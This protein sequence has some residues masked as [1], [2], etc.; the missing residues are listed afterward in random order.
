MRVC[1][2]VRACECGRVCVCVCVNLGMV[3]WS[4]GEWSVLGGS[5]LQNRSKCYYHV[6]WLLI[7]ALSARAG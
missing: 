4:G 3:R 5:G 2:R 6:L 1:V 7:Y